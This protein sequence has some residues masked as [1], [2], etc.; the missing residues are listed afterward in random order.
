MNCCPPEVI[1]A[2]MPELVATGRPAGGYANGFE[3]I[4]E[5]FKLGATVDMLGKR[6]DLGPDAYAGHAMAWVDAGGRIVGGCC[7]VGPAHIAELARRLG[8]AGHAITARPS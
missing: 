7:E 3:P 8:A 1:G 2:A 5:A 6:R 4:P